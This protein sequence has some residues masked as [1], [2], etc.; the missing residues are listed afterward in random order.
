MNGKLYRPAQDSELRYGHRIRIQEV[1]QLDKNTYREQE[2]YI[3]NPPEKDGILGMHTINF[4]EDTVY[5]DF[6]SR[7]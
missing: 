2:A 5:F 7:K 4:T 1:L 3:L 6:Y